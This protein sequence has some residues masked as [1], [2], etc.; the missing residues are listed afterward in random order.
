MNPGPFDQTYTY[1]TT[2]VRTV[3][4]TCPMNRQAQARYEYDLSDPGGSL[5]VLMSSYMAYS[6]RKPKS[7]P[8]V[9]M[10]KPELEPHPRV[11]LTLQDDP[12]PGPKDR[13]EHL[14]LGRLGAAQ[15]VRIVD[16]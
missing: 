3:C 15:L 8:H 14:P 16:L 11:V 7:R 10:Q 2:E 6:C 13:L 9:S 4:M 5:K 12:S 1:L